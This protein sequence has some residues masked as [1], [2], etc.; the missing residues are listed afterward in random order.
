ME[1]KLHNGNK[2]SKKKKLRILFIKKKWYSLYNRS[3]F[4]ELAVLVYINMGKIQDLPSIAV[5]FLIS[6]Y[7][8]N[9]KNIKCIT[10]LTLKNQKKNI[11][12]LI[13]LL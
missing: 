10:I 11:M 1:T 4:T 3:G 6:I 12:Y 8:I 5:G 13:Y 9:A 7:L 2:I